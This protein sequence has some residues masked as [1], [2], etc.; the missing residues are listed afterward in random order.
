MQTCLI[1][2]MCGELETEREMEGL[3]LIWKI[4][5]IPLANTI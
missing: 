3:H 1:W 4:A 2:G 5:V